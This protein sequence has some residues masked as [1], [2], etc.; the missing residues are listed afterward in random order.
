[1]LLLTNVI[2]KQI[3]SIKKYPITFIAILITSLLVLYL[4]NKHDKTLHSVVYL[5]AIWFCMFVTDIIT[6]WKNI[7][8]VEFTVRQ[9]LKETI[10]V[11]ICSLLGM[12]FIFIRFSNPA[13]WETM[14]VPIR[15]ATA[16]LLIFVF[17]IALGIIM[18][19]LKYKFKELGF[20]FSGFVV[21]VPVIMIVAAATYLVSWENNKWI[22]M[23]KS[24]GLV[25]LLF[26]GLIS[27]GL[28]E[29]FWR[30]IAQTRISS[31]LNN[32]G[33]GWFVATLIWAFMHAPKW[34]FED[35]N[36][37]EALMGAIR[38][39]PI[40]L[41]WGY[42]THKTKSVIPA[43]VIHGTNLWGLQNF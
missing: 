19:L 26:A 22:E 14:R 24:E 3:A 41:M 2:N 30:L 5:I 37:F 20:R 36:I 31:F 6:E 11:L 35:R 39:I 13:N 15:L 8:A 28:S 40:G 38:I 27:S 25:G 4:G 32:K 42:I 9:P 21:I 17:P 23:Y 43:A 12:L 34:Y 10:Y 29:E 18:L 7:P 33:L 16:S 1:M